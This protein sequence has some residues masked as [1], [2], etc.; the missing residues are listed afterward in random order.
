MKCLTLQLNNKKCNRFSSRCDGKCGYHTKDKKS[1]SKIRSQAIK[2]INYK[3]PTRIL[4]KSAFLQRTLKI[5]NERQILNKEY[6]YKK[7]YLNINQLLREAKNFKPMF[8]S[9]ELRTNAI[10]MLNLQKYKNTYQM[11]FTS[12]TDGGPKINY[13]TDFYTEKCRLDCRRE[14]K[15]LTPIETY[16]KKKYSL[17]QEAKG[18]LGTLTFENFNRFLDRKIDNCSNY[19][20]SYLL[21]VMDIFKPKKWLDMSAGWGDRL[22]AAIL[23]GVKRYLGVDPNSCLHP[24]YKEM[25]EDL[26]PLSQQKNYEV[27]L[28][29]AENIKL[30]NETFDFIFTSPPFF[31]FEIYNEKG[32]NKE[33]QSTFNYKNVQD[34]LHN[35][36]YKMIDNAWSHL[37]KE[38]NFVLYIEDKSDYPFIPD[39]LK[40]FESKENSIYDGIIYQI[41]YLEDKN[42]PFKKYHTLYCWHK[43]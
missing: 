10:K 2:S 41:P 6:P 16:K 3:R 12:F 15:K 9:N 39:M 32:E 37:E 8:G 31:T 20:L 13:L 19:R 29:Q 23:S 27:L 1:S 11:I 5:D 40:Y 26:I 43:E 4:R 21:G 33:L 25:I 42:P 7:Y 34:W 38:G 17:F 18:N 36:L 35:F 14:Y 22:M 24:Y 30:P 28:G